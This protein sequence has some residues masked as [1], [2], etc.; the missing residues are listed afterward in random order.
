MND[1]RKYRLNCYLV[2][3]LSVSLV[4][5]SFAVW[6]VLAGKPFT[7]CNDQFYQ[8][9][10]FYR[11][12]YR[13]LDRFAQT[14]E[15]PMYSWNMYLGTDFFSSMTYYCTGDLFFLLAFPFLRSVDSVKAFLSLETIAC[16]YISA[17]LFMWLLKQRG[18]KDQTVLLCASLIYAFGGWSISYCG[19]YMF[20]RFYAFFPA[21][22]GGGEYYYR[23]HRT[24]ILSIAVG[25]L[26][27]QNFYLMYPASL[28]L[29]LYCIARE[30]ELKNNCMVFL[31]DTG[32]LL[33][34]YAIG[35]LSA[36]F[37]VCP[38]ILL[39]LSNSRVGNA[40]SGLFWQ[41]KTYL[42]LLLSPICTAFPQFTR[43]NNLFFIDGGSHD[44]WFTVNIG[45]VF[46]V[47]AVGSCFEKENKFRTG[48]LLLLVACLIL[49]PLSSV[50]HGFSEPSFRWMYVLQFY[51][52][53]I[54]SEEFE[55]KRENN[56][57]FAVYFLLCVVAFGVLAARYGTSGYKEQFIV[58]VVCI[59]V[60]AVI[61]VIHSKDRKAAVIVSAA[62]II[63]MSFFYT[64]VRTSDDYHYSS[65][66]SNEETA[67]Y[68][69]LD[70]DL[71]H[72][73]Y[74]SKE[75]TNPGGI[76]AG[77]VNLDYGFL[78]SKTY[79]TMYDNTTDQ[80]NNMTGNSRHFISIED[81]YALTMIGTK[82]WI[83]QDETELPE[84]L[85]FRYAFP[86]SWLKV[87]ENLDYRG[88]G[89]TMDEVKSISEWNSPEDWNKAIYVCDDVDPDAYHG[90]SG[91]FVVTVRGGNYLEGYIELEA[92]NILFIALPDNKGWRV[93]VDGVQ[94]PVLD[95]NGGF[96][97][98]ELSGGYHEIKMSFVSSGLKAGL[99]MSFAGIVLFL[100]VFIYE[101]RKL[102][103]TA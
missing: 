10:L 47:Y 75:N 35:M 91:Q 48:T 98:I 82:Y 85:S 15:L 4:V 69:S 62:E 64:M 74:I 31:K 54:G 14:K 23:K 102:R 87:Y 90:T 44:Y 80:F 42:G 45:I 95:V 16:I 100:V 29:L 72:R 58:L 57:I 19:I 50:M 94:S 40:G 76:L 21:L 78:S 1:R 86:L 9:D 77:N 17:F 88:F 27:L 92:P 46:F 3:F 59:I 34:A 63:V 55:R 32:K 28:F 13:L 49:R 6:L 51:L 61:W 84:E 103:H 65:M 33:L 43:Y 20:H 60:A 67:Y 101:R 5:A 38:A 93:Y 24:W 71:L 8:Y 81:P 26:F 52:L 66:I 97:G 89:Y 37:L 36:G 70:S 12:W 7:I 18:V 22:I 56:K 25:I 39:T 30:L 11:E 68:E 2:L 96:I 41:L 83:V 99:V 53:M 73:Y 79:N